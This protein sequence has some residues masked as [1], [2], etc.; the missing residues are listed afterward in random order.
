MIITGG[1]CRESCCRGVAAWS[2]SHRRV[3]DQ[4]AA[5]APGDPLS[6]Q[7]ASRDRISLIL[8]LRPEAV[9]VRLQRWQR[10]GLWSRGL[11]IL[12][13]GI[14]AF[15]PMPGFAVAAFGIPGLVFFSSG[16]LVWL[17]RGPESWR[18]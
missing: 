9:R 3:R 15:A 16:A 8:P 13:L 4:C 2:G 17:A 18:R 5:L 1:V 7:H 6:I 10:L 12:L 14:A 11:G